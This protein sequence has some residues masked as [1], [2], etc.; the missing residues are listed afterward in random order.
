MRQWIQ[1]GILQVKDLLSE[2]GSYLNYEEFTAKYPNVKANHLL[3]TGIIHSIKNYQ[4]NHKIVLTNR[5]K[6]SESLAW[7][8]IAKGNKSICKFLVVSDVIPAGLKKWN[9][10]YENLPWKQIFK[11]YVQS[12]RDT[13]LR[14]FQYRLLL[15]ILPTNRYLFLRKVIDSSQ[16][17][18][19][20]NEEETIGHL[21]WT[22][23]VTAA[24]WASL[25][26][27]IKNTCDSETT[28]DFSEIL[29]LFGIKEDT[30][31]NRVIDFILLLAKFYIYKCKWNKTSPN[32]TAF[33]GIL[34]NRYKEERHNNLIM[35]NKHVFE[36]RWLRYMPLLQ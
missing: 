9:M 20:S 6:L 22:C 33:I 13:Q 31:T 35:D 18:F 1:S 11:T 30:V 4:N 28:L 7:T 34:R 24:F 5:Y 25:E 19:C 32:I 12:T 27:L 16:C 14:W 26:T 8:I 29:I 10:K 21:F 36:E 23:P 3:F 15:R 2:N 17:T